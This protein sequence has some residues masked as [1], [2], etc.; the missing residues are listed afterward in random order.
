MGK[1]RG[2]SYERK[3]CTLPGNHWRWESWATRVRVRLLD[4]KPICSE[5]GGCAKRKKESGRSWSR[6]EDELGLRPADSEVSDKSWWTHPTSYRKTLREDVRAEGEDSRVY[7][8]GGG[9][10]LWDG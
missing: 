10:M 6:G 1:E 8:A 7:M 4:F 2:E 3:K 5:K 9:S